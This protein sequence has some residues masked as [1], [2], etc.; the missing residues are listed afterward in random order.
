MFCYNC[1]D[2][3]EKI[4]DQKE[5]FYHQT[6]KKRVKFG[7]KFVVKV[8]FLTKIFSAAA[9]VF[10]IKHIPNMFFWSAPQMVCVSISYARQFFQT[11][12]LAKNYHHSK[13]QISVNVTTGI[14][15][16]PPLEFFTRCVPSACNK[17]LLNFVQT[18]QRS[19]GRPVGGEVVEG[20]CIPL[21]GIFGWVLAYF[22]LINQV[23][24]CEL[25]RTL[26]ILA[27]V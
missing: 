18:C 10:L 12:K 8:L 15:R 23:G 3:G 11:Q 7:P 5:H 24:L 13:T 1:F 14:F 9:E 20:C 21:I 6:R 2:N 27:K 17:G 16:H 22:G 19:Y 26:S 25:R 4:I